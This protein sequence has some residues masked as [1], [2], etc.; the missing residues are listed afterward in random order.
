M[1]KF[2][3]L[4][5]HP[6]HVKFQDAL[7]LLF[8]SGSELPWTI[9][10]SRII[11]WVTRMH[12][13]FADVVRACLF[14]SSSIL[15]AIYKVTCARYVRMTKLWSRNKLVENF[16]G[17]F[18]T[19]MLMPMCLVDSCFLRFDYTSDILVQ[20]RI[21]GLCFLDSWSML[22]QLSFQYYIWLLS[23]KM[24]LSHVLD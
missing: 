8:W 15:L 19:N 9:M 14:R 24:M 13:M 16:M 22:C 20:E 2:S 17:E 12:M 7:W 11:S 21:W 1:I 3:L 18:I 4:F 6:H 23:S 10:T 5:E